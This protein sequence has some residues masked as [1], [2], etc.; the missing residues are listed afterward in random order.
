MASRII[1]NR[2]CRLDPAMAGKMLFVSDN[3]KWWQEQLG[4]HQVAEDE[5]VVEVMEE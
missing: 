3:W 1:S 5:D 4:F 2:R